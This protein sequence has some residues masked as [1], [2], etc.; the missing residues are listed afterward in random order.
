VTREREREREIER[1][2]EREREKERDVRKT[3]RAAA[4]SAAATPSLFLDQPMDGLYTGSAAAAWKTTSRPYTR[5]LLNV[6][7]YIL[8]VVGSKKDVMYG[9]R[10]KRGRCF[11]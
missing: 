7:H 3:I 5:D 10:K 4:T 6:S 9:A 1:E 11:E 8:V 2:R